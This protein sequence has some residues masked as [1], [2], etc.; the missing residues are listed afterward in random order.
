M[1]VNILTV[2]K[3]QT[4]LNG[5]QELSWHYIMDLIFAQSYHLQC[6]LLTLVIPGSSLL[7]AMAE[8]RRYSVESPAAES[9]FHGVAWCVPDT[10]DTA[11]I[12]QD[13]PEH[14]YLFTLS[15]HVSPELKLLTQY[16]I[17]TYQARMWG[18][19][20]RLTDSWNSMMRDRFMNHANDV[21]MQP[22][23]HAARY[24]L[25]LRKQ[26]DVPT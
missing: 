2:S 24:H 25:Y 14:D 20:V 19:G 7:R 26:T 11:L 17:W 16:S 10:G 8:L 18:L 23:Y 6:Q 9:I 3:V 12:G 22:G 15:P 21:F 1:N 5:P 4:Q 13:I